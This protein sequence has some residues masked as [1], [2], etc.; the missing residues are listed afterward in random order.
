[1][2]TTIG[3]TRTAQLIRRPEGPAHLVEL[4]VLA[5]EAGLHPEVACALLRLGL[6]ESAGGTGRALLFPRDAVTAGESLKG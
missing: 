6:I 4:D 5:H 1:M 2:T 3:T